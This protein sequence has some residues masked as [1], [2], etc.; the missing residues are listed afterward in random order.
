MYNRTLKNRTKLLGVLFLSATCFLCSSCDKE[1]D[2]QPIQL[3]YAL[4][5]DKPNPVTNNQV[6]IS[7]PDETKT[8]LVIF[9]G[10]G[11]YSINN[12]DDTKL[13][14]NQNDGYLTLTP[15]AVGNIVVTINDRHNNFYTL[16]VQIKSPLRVKMNVK[17][18][19]GTI[20]GLMEFNLF[21]YSEKDFTLL[22]L[23]EAYDSLVWVCSNTKQR[24]K[25]LEYSENSSHFT[26]KW[27]TCFFLPAEYETVLLGYKNNL[28][29]TRDTVTVNIANKKDFLGF[30]WDDVV[31]TSDVST[32][33]E[34]V[35]SND[36]YFVTHPVVTNDAPSM[37]LYLHPTNDSEAVFAPKSKQILFDYIN[38]LYSAPNHSSDENDTLSD[39]YHDLF[40]NTKEGVIPEFIWVTSASKIALLKEYDNIEGYSKYEI[41]AEPIK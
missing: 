4:F 20:F 21:S 2:F 28:I 3:Q 14:I 23:T 12:S 35:F 6:T 41:Y 17:E 7:F 34:D 36:Y 10:D 11:T 33:Y 26:W 9:G 40:K 13:S 22:N 15:L 8:E 19:E 39:V 24:Y 18:K 25:I 30:N 16:K 38:S 32:G 29:I 37:Y 5:N 31:S 1:D 27:S